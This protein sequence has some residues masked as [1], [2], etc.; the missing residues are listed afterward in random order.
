[1]GVNLG[2]RV[3]PHHP[4]VGVSPG[5]WPDRDS[6]HYI[7]SLL[8]SPSG[9]FTEETLPGPSPHPGFVTGQTCWRHEKV[10]P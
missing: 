10:Y 1:M 2:L 4:I 6:K 9:A 7:A 8:A 5:E 3:P